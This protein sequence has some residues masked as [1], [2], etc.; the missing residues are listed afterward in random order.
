VAPAAR[1]IITI[2]RAWESASTPQVCPFDLQ[3]GAE[4]HELKED[5]APGALPHEPIACTK[6]FQNF[7]YIFIIFIT[8]TGKKPE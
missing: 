2:I 3:K 6:F 7:T 5:L 8:S 4:R 1:N